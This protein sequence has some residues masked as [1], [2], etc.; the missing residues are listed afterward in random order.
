MTWICN[1]M[2]KQLAF[3]FIFDATA[4]KIR[5]RATELYS[6]VNNVTRIYQ[7]SRE[8]FSLQQDDKSLERK[9]SPSLSKSVTFFYKHRPITTNIRQMEGF[10][11]VS[12]L[13]MKLSG[14]KF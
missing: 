14:P 6:G 4:K 8:Y 11:L 1:N 13:N 5:D 7:T 3:N 10:F 12:I 2:N 9:L